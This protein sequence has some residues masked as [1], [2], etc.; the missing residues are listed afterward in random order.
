MTVLSGDEMEWRVYCRNGGYVA[1]GFGFYRLLLLDD[2]WSDLSGQGPPSELI[3]TIVK[4][5]RRRGG[6]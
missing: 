1:Q 2:R 3:E 4:T 5:V 6:K